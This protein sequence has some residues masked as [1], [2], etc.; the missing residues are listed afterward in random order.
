MSMAL[1]ADGTPYWKWQTL[2]ETDK[3]SCDTNVLY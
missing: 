2:F 3:L 1:I